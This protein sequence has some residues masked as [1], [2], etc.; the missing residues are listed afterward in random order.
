MLPTTTAGIAGGLGQQAMQNIPPAA[1]QEVPYGTQPPNLNNISFVL[2]DQPH[3]QQQPPPQ[4]QH[5]MYPAITNAQQSQN[6][7]YGEEFEYYDE[8]DDGKQ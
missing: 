8:E 4:Q 7:Q 5:P 1:I 2:D 6:Q 3:Q